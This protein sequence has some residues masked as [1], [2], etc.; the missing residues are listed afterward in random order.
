MFLAGVIYLFYR[1]PSFLIVPESITLGW[2]IIRLI[3]Y[4]TIVA[5]AL[6]VVIGLGWW[7]FVESGQDPNHSQYGM[8]TLFTA[9]FGAAFLTPICTVVIVW[10]SA[11]DRPY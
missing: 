2:V 4:A 11:K 3:A 8:G 10:F 5:V 9:V 1:F 7:I 6:A